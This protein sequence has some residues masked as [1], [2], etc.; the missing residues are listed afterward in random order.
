MEGNN[1]IYFSDNGWYRRVIKSKSKITIGQKYLV[2]K[3]MANILVIY[4]INGDTWL[5]GLGGIAVSYISDTPFEKLIIDTQ[6]SV[7]L[8]WFFYLV[9]Y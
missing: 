4:V 1:I 2:K 3:I 5:H 7:E 6:L 9:Y 8:G